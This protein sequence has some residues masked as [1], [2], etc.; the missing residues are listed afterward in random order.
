[1]GELTESIEPPPTG[2][3][4]AKWGLA[5]W[6]RRSNWP[7]ALAALPVNCAIVPVAYADAHRAN[8]PPVEE[9]CRAACE[10]GFAAVLIDTF[11]KDGRGLL[12]WTTLETISQWRNHCRSAGVK[13]AVAGSLTLSEMARLASLEPDWFAV[14]GAACR[15]GN[16]A[17]PVEE[18]RVRAL[19]DGIRSGFTRPM[20]A[21]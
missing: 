3:A 17:G 8:S 18:H 16:R 12:D 9:V 19:V 13:F 7:D 5:G 11:L 2:L 6:A 15:Q 10:R 1:M 14:R 20:F 21:S 4:Y